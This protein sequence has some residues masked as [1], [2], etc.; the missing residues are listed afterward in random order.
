MWLRGTEIQNCLCVNGSF[1]RFSHGRKW[2]MWVNHSSHSFQLNPIH[3]RELLSVPRGNTLFLGFLNLLLV[4]LYAERWD[5]T[6]KSFILCLYPCINSR[7][8]V[9]RL[10]FLLR[11]PGFL[12]EPKTFNLQW[13]KRLRTQMLSLQIKAAAASQTE[14]SALKRGLEGRE[15]SGP[16]GAQ[17]AAPDKGDDGKP[18]SLRLRTPSVS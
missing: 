16:G 7:G 2:G 17:E 1:L 18:R 6:H 8:C 3:R 5:L 10:M 15:T 14:V 12:F 9:C 4:Y 11:H 13:V